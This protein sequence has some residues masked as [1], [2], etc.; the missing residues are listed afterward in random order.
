[1]VS[2]AEFIPIAEDCGLILPIG[3]WALRMAVRQMRIWHGR[4]LPDC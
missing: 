3:E 2:P 4:G 1:M